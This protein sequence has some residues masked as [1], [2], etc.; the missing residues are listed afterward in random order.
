M[1]IILDLQMSYLCNYL[2][3]KKIVS[4]SESEKKL[5]VSGGIDCKKTGTGNRLTVSFGAA[6][7]S[8]FTF[9]EIR[10]NGVSNKELII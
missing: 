3:S 5:T 9:T 8:D 4:V 10:Q 7:F 1:A 2:S 6:K